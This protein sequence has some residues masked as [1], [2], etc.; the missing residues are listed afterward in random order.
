M[1]YFILSLLVCAVIAACGNP[2]GLPGAFITNRVDTVSLY[3]L[4]GTPVSLPSGYSITAR[5]EVRPDQQLQSGQCAGSECEQRC[6][7][8]FEYRDV[9]V[10]HS[11]GLLRE[12]ARPDDRHDLHAQRAPDQLRDSHRSQLRLSRAPNRPAEPVSRDRPEVVARLARSG[13]RGARAPR[14]YVVDTTARRDRSARYEAPH[15]DRAA[16]PAEGGAQRCREGRRAGGEVPRRTAGSDNG[17]AAQT[18]RAD[19]RVRV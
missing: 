4:S 3:A 8:A 13:A 2:L 9:L 15:A 7:P 14:R 11:R 1:R 19:H 18:W 6:R 16:R 10:R 17:G 12:A 5:R